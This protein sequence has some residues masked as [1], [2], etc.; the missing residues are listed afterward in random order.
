MRNGSSGETYALDGRWHG[1]GV[2]IGQGFSELM[3]SRRKNRMVRP[4][5][6]RLRRRA[7]RGVGL[8]VVMMVVASAFALG[9]AMMR[10]Q[11]TMLLISRNEVRSGNARQAAVSGL[12]DAIWRMHQSSEWTGA[13][14]VYVETLSDTDS[15]QVTYATGD[16]R[17]ESGD[18]DYAMWPYRVTITSRG[19]SMDKSSPGVTSVYEVQAVVQLVPRALGPAPTDWDTM[20][21]YTLYQRGDDDIDINVP[22]RIG[23]PVR[24][25]GR[26]T[27]GEQYNWSDTI[28]DRYFD[29]LSAMEGAAVA[30]YRPFEGPVELPFSETDTE[31][32]DLLATHLGVTAVDTPAAADPGWSGLV[33]TSSYRLY[34]GGKSYAIPVLGTSLGN[35]TIGADVTTNPLGIH[36]S[37]SNVTI[38]DNVVIEG[39]LLVEADL[40]LRG[41]GIVASAVSAPALDGET[42]PVRLPP[43]ACDDLDVGNTDVSAQFSGTVIAWRSSLIRWGESDVQFDLAG[44]LITDEIA[45][46]SRW[47]WPLFSSQWNTVY[48]NF[49]AQ[50]A[51]GN[52]YL[53]SYMGSAYSY[54]PSPLITISPDSGVTREHFQDPDDPIYAVKAGDDG[55]VWDVVWMADVTP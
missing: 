19:I 47:D 26:L 33:E 29:D 48:S 10:S 8:L 5:T 27:L 24:L 38:N 14:S 21:G 34:P 7:R 2:G 30:D 11:S 50:E 52:P 16:P 18:A 6:S 42:K 46:Q 44:R 43:I 20:L 53:P 23:G 49:V 17:L 36:F 54:D 39:T 3:S 25:N 1:L 37:S 32:L 4:A 45:V 22:A 12:N 9:Y 15:F 41:T 35:E 40:D 13:D 28:R 51:G 31:H 55:L